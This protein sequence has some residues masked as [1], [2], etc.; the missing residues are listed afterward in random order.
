MLRQ[1]A[2]VIQVGPTEMLQGLRNSCA[3][4]NEFE[5]LKSRMDV[6][7]K[8]DECIKKLIAI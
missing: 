4:N 3:M 2:Q 7:K 8:V 5:K 6:G 1:N